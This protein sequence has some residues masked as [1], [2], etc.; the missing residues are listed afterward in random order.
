MNKIN[1][2]ECAAEEKDLEKSES[3][4]SADVFNEDQ[5]YSLKLARCVFISRN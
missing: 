1:F 3:R 5:A 4:K 2:R